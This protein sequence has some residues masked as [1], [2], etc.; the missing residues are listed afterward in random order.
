MKYRLDEN[1]LEVL[2]RLYK[3]KDTGSR[4]NGLVRLYKFDGASISVWHTGTVLVQGKKAEVYDNELQK[5]FSKELT[6]VTNKKSSNKDDSLV[7]NQEF[8]IGTDEVGNGSFIGGMTAAAVYVGKGQAEKLRE[9][10]VADSKNISDKSIPTIAKQIMK[11][12]PFYVL[13]AYPDKYNNAI[14]KGYNQVSLKVALHNRCAYLLNKKYP[15]LDI[16]RFIVDGFT[17][18]WNW[19]KYI[20]EE[21]DVFHLN[22]NLYTKAES[23]YLAVAAASILARYSFL[24]QIQELSARCGLDLHQGVTSNVKSDFKDLQSRGFDLGNFVKLHFKTYKEW[25]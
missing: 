24:L 23:K 1:N 5:H 25:L 17:Q 7:P 12:C 8:I 16:R 19:D 14:D 4:I 21:S 11:L 22:A 9:I 18:P 10:G 6:I 13:S 15:N 2:D 3:D 20:K